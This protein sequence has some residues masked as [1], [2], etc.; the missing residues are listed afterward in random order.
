[1]KERKTKTSQFFKLLFGVLL[2]T[3]GLGLSS[4][5]TT[6]QTTDLTGNSII[7]NRFAEAKAAYLKEDWLEAIRILDEIRLQAPTS[8]IASEAT[9]LEGM[10]R[11]NAGTYISAAVDFRATRRNYPASELAPRSQFMVAESY[12]MLSPRPELDQSFSLSALSEYQTF[13]RDYSG[14]EI[15]LVDSAQMRI[16]DIRN[17]L[18]MKYLLAAELYI[19]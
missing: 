5:G 15:S 6:K 9:F 3:S 11:Y 19:K 7:E 18:G 13:L 1:M 8:N 16:I 10:S 12:N 14:A 17:K 2:A 4:C